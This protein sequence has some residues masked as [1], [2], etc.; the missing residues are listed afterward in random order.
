MLLLYFFEVATLVVKKANNTIGAA[1][2]I[3]IMIVNKDIKTQSPLRVSSFRRTY[4]FPSMAIKQPHN[5]VS[6]LDRLGAMPA[7]TAS[8]D[9][10]NCWVNYTRFIAICLYKNELPTYPLIRS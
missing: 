2:I 8:L 6:V 1:M 5:G 9:G 10:L 7:E 3:K 4:W